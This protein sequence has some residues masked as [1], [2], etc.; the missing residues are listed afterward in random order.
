MPGNFQDDDRENSMR[1]LF[2]L[3]K[4]DNE[5]RSGIDAFLDLEG[6]AIPFE[7]KTTSQ[8]SVTTVRDF[9]PDHIE[10]WQDKHWLIGFFLKGKEYYKY[11]S[12]AMMAPWIDSKEQYISPDFK[13]ANLVPAKITRKDMY[14]ILGQKKIYPTFRTLTDKKIF[15]NLLPQKGI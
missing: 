9:G 13:L 3:Y 5:G 7:L 1:E 10:K 4:D 12:P 11:G 14:E 2:E 15:Y 6:K 8:G